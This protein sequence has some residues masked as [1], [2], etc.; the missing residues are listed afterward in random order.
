MPDT[1]ISAF[2]AAAN[3]VNADELPIVQAL[4][5]AKCTRQQLLEAGI[6]E[7]ITVKAQGLNS[8]SLESGMAGEKVVLDD[9]FGYVGNSVIGWI[10]VITGT[11][12]YIQ[13]SS[14]GAVLISSHGGGANLVLSN[15]GT[16]QSIA[17]TGA[18]AQIVFVSPAGVFIPFLIQ[19]PGAIGNWAV[20]VPVDYNLAINRL[21]AAVAGLLGGPIP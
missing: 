21:A 10:T 17:L 13:L 20:G 8:V 5:N 4:V 19:A 11:N 18:G 12:G 3:V 7:N 6:G 9:T 1:K 16:G 15:A 14:T 2:P